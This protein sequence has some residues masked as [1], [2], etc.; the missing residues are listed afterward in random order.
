VHLGEAL[1]YYRA[2]VRTDSLFGFAAIRGAQAAIWNHRASEAASL[3]Q[4]AL[5]QPMP[6]RYTHFAL[7]YEAYL[8]GR[9]DSAAAEF[10]RALALDPEMAA[11][12]MQLGEVYTH[13]LP[14]AGDPQD[15]AEV[16]FEEAHRLDPS[17][18][19]LLLHLIEIRLRKGDPARAQPLVRQFLAADPDPMLAKQ[20]QI[21]Q[22]C[23]QEGPLAVDWAK[24]AAHST[25]SVLAAGKMLAAGGAQLNCAMPAFS[26]V[27]KADTTTAGDSRWYALFQLQAALLAHGEVSKAARQIDSSPPED[28]AS[29]MYLLDAPLFPEL[30]DKAAEVARKFK[31]ECGLGYAKCPNPYRVWQ[32]GLWDA[33]RGHTVEAELAARELAARAKRSSSQDLQLL[34]LLGRSVAAHAA[35]ARSDT[36]TALVLFGAS[37]REAVP[38]GQGIEWDLGKPRGIDRLRFAQLLF[39]R[40]QS[41]QAIDVSDMFD[42][43]SPSVYLLYLTESLKL[44][45]KAANALG[46]VARAARYQKRLAVLRGDR[47]ITA[48]KTRKESVI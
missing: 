37:V 42:S 4:V 3:I 23:V 21:M 35:L 34:S 39:A 48:V 10:R 8:E 40:G 46:D 20:I 41:E 2:A 16:A 47:S 5:K 25:L 17:A 44:R 36:A 13:L 29:A 26:A 9:A 32:L 15:Q 33:Y 30:S 22:T 7:G 27:I 14:V 6:L 45:L 1:K 43:A 31:A 19:N 12:W 18:T 38:G 28:V 24:E 11:A